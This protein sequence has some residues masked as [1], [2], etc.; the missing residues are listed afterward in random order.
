MIISFICIQSIDYFFFFILRIYSS[1]IFE[2]TFYV[3]NR[4]I[5]YSKRFRFRPQPGTKPFLRKIRSIHFHQS[6]FSTI[7]SAFIA[8]RKNGSTSNRRGLVSQM[9]YKFRATWPTA[10]K[11]GRCE[12]IARRSVRN[13]KE[14][15]GG[16][17]AVAHPSV[18]VPRAVA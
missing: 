12:P 4:I 5:N 11:S 6:S 10:R 18:L 9:T 17:S 3:L 16:N 1:H 2:H 14:I 13:A 7:Q 15:A 8:G